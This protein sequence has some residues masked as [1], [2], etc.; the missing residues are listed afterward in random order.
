MLESVPRVRESS[1]R[2]EKRGFRFVSCSV[3]CWIRYCFAFSSRGRVVLKKVG[4]YRRDLGFLCPCVRVSVRG[5]I[6]AQ[7]KI[8]MCPPPL[9]IKDL[10]DDDDED[11]DDERT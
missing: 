2:G 7:G 8:T 4:F 9:M 10:I 5:I 6:C 3:F 11:N 1:E